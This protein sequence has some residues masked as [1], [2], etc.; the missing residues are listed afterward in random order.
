[1]EQQGGYLEKDIFPP[2]LFFTP[3]SLKAEVRSPTARGISERHAAKLDAFSASELLHKQTEN[4]RKIKTK[5]WFDGS[6]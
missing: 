5:L 6:G 1:M 2:N 3:Y 4:L